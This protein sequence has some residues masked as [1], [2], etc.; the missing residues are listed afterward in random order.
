M[1]RHLNLILTI[2]STSSFAGALLGIFVPIYFLS[3]HFSLSAIFIYFIV[4]AVSVLVLFLAASIFISKLGVKKIMYFSFPVQIIYIALL[5]LLPSRNIPLN[6]IALVSGF[7][8]AFYWLPLHILFTQ[9]T[10]NEQ[11]GSSVGKFFAFPQLIKILGPVIG[12][13]ITVS[14]G[15]GALIITT[16]LFYLLAAV[17]ILGIKE[18]VLVPFNASHILKYFKS[19]PK[20]IIVEFTENIREEIE[21]IIW[22]I[23]VFLTFK[24]IFTVGMVGAL[25]GIGSFLFI[26]LLGKFSDKTNKKLLIKIGGL[27][28][29]ALMISRYFA[30]NEISFYLITLL[31]GFIGTTILIPFTSIIYKMTKENQTTEFL[32][33][34][35]FPITLA[36]VLVYSLAFLLVF[37]LKL[38]FPI[39]A[40]LSCLY[41]IF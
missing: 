15:F 29:I 30:Q 19:F 11:L 23:Y 41:L 27:L 36:R 24:N 10:N 32:A 26:F 5:Y 16:A 2:Q 21:A 1:K 39:T 34:R 4:Q 38:I 12:G 3:L 7:Q 33:F 6:L 20:Y 17:P 40:L 25:L 37:N 31:G 18:D 35:E 13:A 22:P 14:L 8:S 9:N 28:L